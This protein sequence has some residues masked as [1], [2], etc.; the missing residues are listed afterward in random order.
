MYSTRHLSDDLIF[1]G[2]A[3]EGLLV[4]NLP[5][6]TIRETKSVVLSNTC[7]NDLQNVRMYSSSICYSPIFNLNKY[8]EKLKTKTITSPRKVS[9]FTN[10][11]KNQRISQ[12]FFLPKGGKLISDS[13]IFFDK[14]NS[15]DNNSISREGLSK[16]RLFSFSNYGFYLFVFKL[17][18]HFSRI[19]EDLDRGKNSFFNKSKIILAF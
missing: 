9:E 18:M 2:D 15:C 10:Q 13:F 1:Q 19:R 6:P 5:N 16:R 17:S 7:D 4:I 8:I 11:I 3:L 14:I 12:I